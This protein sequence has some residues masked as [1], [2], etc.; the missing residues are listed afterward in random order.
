MNFS[1]TQASL[2]EVAIASTHLDMQS[3]IKRIYEC[4]QDDRKCPMKLI[5]HVSKT[6]PS[7]SYLMII[8]DALR[9][10]QLINNDYKFSQKYSYPK[11]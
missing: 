9:Y 6:P 1:I 7:L 2:V 10:C 11:I 5:P 8:H 3:T 4:L